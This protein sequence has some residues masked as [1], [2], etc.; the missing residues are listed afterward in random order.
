MTETAHTAEPSVVQALAEVA[1]DVREVRK[2]EKNS[3]GGYNFRGIDAVMNAVGPALRRHGVLCM[4]TTVDLQQ[5][6]VQTT[7][8]KPQTSS[9][10]L[11]RYTFHGPSGDSVSAEVWG[12]SWDSSDKGLAQAYSVAYRT[13]LLQALTIPTDDPDPDSKHPQLDRE[14]AATAEQLADIKGAL[15]FLEPDAAAELKAWWKEQ[16]YPGVDSG[17]LTQSQAAA[18]VDRLSVSATRQGVAQPVGSEGTPAA[19]ESEEVAAATSPAVSS[20]TASVDAGSPDPEQTQQT[21]PG[22]GAPSS[23]ARQALKKAAKP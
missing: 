11:V 9:K 22:S 5:T 7:S 6:V 1:A 13:C 10:V 20:L 4:P 17:H 15:G 21:Q 18:I 8:G 19:S 12:E 2:A 3:H 23:A 14:P 16:R